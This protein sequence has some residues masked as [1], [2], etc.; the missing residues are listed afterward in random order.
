LAALGV[1]ILADGLIDTDSGPI[2]YVYFDTEAQ[3]KYVLGLISFPP[4]ME[5]RP[6]PSTENGELKLSQYAMVIRDL[7]AVSAFWKKLGFPDMEVTHP[8]LRN[9]RYRGGL[10]EFDQQLGWQR[11]GEVVYEWIV[12][13]KGPTV[14][15]DHLKAHGEGIH[16]LAFDTADLDKAC[17]KFEG[18]GFPVVQ[19]GAWGE[20]GK[21]GSGRFAY[22]DTSKVG[23][24]VVELLWNYRP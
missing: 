11:H 1:G 21:P 13:L 17:G 12:P 9:L 5:S 2:H 8:A 16:H 24:A 7:P 6:T 15:E 4:G 20:D 22:S 23:G 14:Y 10:G 18:A 3:G 19:S